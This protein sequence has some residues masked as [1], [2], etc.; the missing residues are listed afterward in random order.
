MP[1]INFC[2]ITSFVIIIILLLLQID[3]A[4]SE[5]S[6][7]SDPD[8]VSDSGPVAAAADNDTE[9]L[10]PTLARPMSSVSAS[11]CTTAC[12]GRPVRSRTTMRRPAPV[13]TPGSAARPRAATVAATV[14]RGRGRKRRPV[15]EPSSASDTDSEPAAAPQGR[16]RGLGRGRQA[17][18]VG[19]RGDAIDDGW[20]LL[21]GEESE[22]TVPSWISTI[23][24]LATRVIRT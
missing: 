2:N 22:A 24:T 14:G 5:P 20:R 17:R 1:E 12:S 13:I 10:G 16:G 6:P 23:G 15:S 8:S 11:T 9:A 3:A 21:E 19:G 4:V 18:T 7:S